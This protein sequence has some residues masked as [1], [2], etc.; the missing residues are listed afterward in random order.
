M[1]EPI[2]TAIEACKAKVLYHSDFVQQPAEL[3]ELKALFLQ[4]GQT[5][6]QQAFLAFVEALVRAPLDM[7]TLDNRVLARLGDSGVRSVLDFG[8]EGIEMLADV[9]RLPEL[10]PVPKSV[11]GSGSSNTWS[12][13]CG[14]DIP[15]MR[16]A[17]WILSASGSLKAHSAIVRCLK[18][19]DQGTRVNAARALA[20]MG[21][22]WSVSPLLAQLNTFLRNAQA[23]RTKTSSGDYK[24]LRTIVEAL[25][26]ILQSAGRDVD[27]SVL[28]ETT[29]LPE[30]FQGYV[31]EDPYWEYELTFK[32][33]IGLANQTA[34]DLRA[35]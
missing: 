26:K 13:N 22:A 7:S 34:S 2:R 3:D 14:E 16:A 21:K 12:V 9:L 20:A 15:F 1:Q 24:E 10:V 35:G 25:T 33:L 32:D 5:R 11:K 19:Q 23:G 6:S 4:E 28:A 30:V 8:D 27:G 17:L 18:S 29:R 31:S